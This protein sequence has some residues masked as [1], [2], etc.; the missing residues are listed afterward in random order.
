MFFRPGIVATLGSRLIQLYTDRVLTDLIRRNNIL[1]PAVLLL[2]Y[3]IPLKA[4]RWGQTVTSLTLFLCMLTN[5]YYGFVGGNVRVPFSVIDPAG[6]VF[7][8]NTRF[9]KT[10]CLLIKSTAG[11]QLHE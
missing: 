9:E 3:V 4:S 1:P 10:T 2:S 11:K 5:K 8:V 6:I 7:F